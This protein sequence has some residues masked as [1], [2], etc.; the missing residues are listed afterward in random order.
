MRK[1]LG[2][3]PSP[4]F[5]LIGFVIHLFEI[6]FDFCKYNAI[7]IDNRRGVFGECDM[8][9]NRQGKS[10]MNYRLIGISVMRSFAQP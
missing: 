9:E 8:V 1:G 7:S 4:Y 10:S 3:V 6:L 2:F 5:Y